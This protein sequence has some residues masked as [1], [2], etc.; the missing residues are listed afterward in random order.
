M[1]GLA[2]RARS[3]RMTGLVLLALCIPRVFIYD[4]E[5]AKY[6]IAAFIVLGLLLLWVGFSYQQF[7]HLIESSND[8]KTPE[9]E[10]NLVTSRCACWV[11]DQKYSH[12]VCKASFTYDKVALHLAT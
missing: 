1:L 11:L 12:T 5:E 10:A 8:P 7:R 3:H 6:R 2:F 9:Q 4:I